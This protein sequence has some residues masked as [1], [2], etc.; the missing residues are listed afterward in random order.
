M[1]A[2]FRLENITHQTIPSSFIL[3]VSE[4]E[5]PEYWHLPWICGHRLKKRPH[6]HRKQKVVNDE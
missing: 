2:P 5:S 1:M 3:I 4:M 6:K